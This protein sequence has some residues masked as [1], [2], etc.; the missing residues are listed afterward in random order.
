[1]D[2]LRHGF[3]QQIWQN[4][5]PTSDIIS[6]L[7][8][9]RTLQTQ[10]SSTCSKWSFQLETLPTSDNLPTGLYPQ[11]LDLGYWV[12]KNLDGPGHQIIAHS[13]TEKLPVAWFWSPECLTHNWGPSDWDNLPQ[14]PSNASD[15]RAA[16]RLFVTGH[17]GLTIIGETNNKGWTINRWEITRQSV[18]YRYECLR[19]SS[20]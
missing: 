9:N 19:I 7:T 5:H 12:E 3:L 17:R 13:V 8:F 10:D 4:C 15:G 11:C 1:M 2:N 14:G 16:F 20:L 18:W 6:L